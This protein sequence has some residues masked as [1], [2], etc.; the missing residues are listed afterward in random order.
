MSQLKTKEE[1]GVLGP[2]EDRKPESVDDIDDNLDLG[3]E[4][5]LVTS[6][7]SKELFEKQD[8]ELSDSGPS[9]TFLD[10]SDMLMS[11]EHHLTP[12]MEMCCLEDLNLNW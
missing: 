11:T 12:E 3:T 10:L 4:C 7:G 2:A 8:E 5:W 1:V 9:G 6:S